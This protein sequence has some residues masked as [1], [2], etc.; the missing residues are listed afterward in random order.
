MLRSP[1][2]SRLGSIYHTAIVE[3]PYTRFPLAEGASFPKERRLHTLMRR[4]VRLSIKDRR[5]KIFILPAVVG[6]RASGVMRI[7]PYYQKLKRSLQGIAGNG[8]D[9]GDSLGYYIS[10]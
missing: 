6:N 3:N 10:L 5:D 7:A 8:C 1:E 2:A 4:G 9:I